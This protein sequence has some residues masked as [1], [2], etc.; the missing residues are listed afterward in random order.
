[1][2]ECGNHCTTDVTTGKNVPQLNQRLPQARLEQGG[3]G[4]KFQKFFAALSD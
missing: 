2:A 4:L 1:L 3:G